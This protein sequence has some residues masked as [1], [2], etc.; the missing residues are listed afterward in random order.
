MLNIFKEKPN[1]PKNP[2]HFREFAVK[3][4]TFWKF[5]TYCD[6]NNFESFDDALEELLKKV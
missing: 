3:N 5:Y 4:K 1:N 6:E 2:E